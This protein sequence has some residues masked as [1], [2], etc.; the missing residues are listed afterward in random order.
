MVENPYVWSE[1]FG[2]NWSLFKEAVINPKTIFVYDIDGILANSAKIVFADFVKKTGIYASPL[3]INEWNFLSSLAKKLGLTTEQI[4]H[5]DDGWY[6]PELL[7]AAETYLYIKPVVQ[8]TTSLVGPDNN[9]VLTSRNFRLRDSTN[10][11]V[12]RKFP[13]ILEQNIL[14]RDS[15]LIG[16]TEFKV[17]NLDRLSKVG[18]W[19]V[20]IDDALDFVDASLK[21]KIPNLV[22][23][24]IPM[25][26][27]WPNFRH[28]QLI[29]IN[30]Y[31]KRIQAMY[32]FMDA[33]FMA[34]K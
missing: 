22:V 9:F 16:A 21:A 24:N 11:W 18:P 27:Y 13:E 19:V 12:G 26:K 3:E 8:R 4:L 17:D 14:M 15:D 2:G 1:L 30:R 28:D 33:V 31:P 34:T 6:D 5:A 7:L 25:G 10:K 29:L 32:P 23:V 20:F